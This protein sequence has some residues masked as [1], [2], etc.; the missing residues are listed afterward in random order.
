MQ[1]RDLRCQIIR[2]GR[3]VRLVFRIQVITKSLAFCIKHARAIIGLVILVQTAQ[4]VENA[5]NRTGRLIAVVAQ[6]RQ[7]VESAIQVG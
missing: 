5:M 2:H 7:C 4:H 1:R 3:A 6:I